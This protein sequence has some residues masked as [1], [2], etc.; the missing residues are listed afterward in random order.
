MQ[1]FEHLQWIQHFQLPEQLRRPQWILQFRRPAQLLL[2]K[3]REG[4]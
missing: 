4:S 3:Q 1:Q 2:Q